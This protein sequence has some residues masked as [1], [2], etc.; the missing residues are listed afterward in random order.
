M[1]YSTACAGS[2][3]GV[4]ALNAPRSKAHPLARLSRH[5]CCEGRP[6]GSGRG[7]LRR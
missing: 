6:Q 7:F 4:K 5:L 1:P 3:L 2:G